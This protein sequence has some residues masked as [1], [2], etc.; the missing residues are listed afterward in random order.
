ML[1]YNV[2]LYLSKY[3]CIGLQYTNLFYFYKGFLPL[4]II[5]PSI[6]GNIFYYKCQSTNS[7]L[8]VIFIKMSFYRLIVYCKFIY[9]SFIHALSSTTV[10]NHIFDI[11]INSR[12]ANNDRNYTSLHN[13]ILYLSKYCFYVSI[14]RNDHS[15]HRDFLF[16][17]MTATDKMC[18]Y[19]I[20]R[21]A[22][23]SLTLHAFSTN[24]Y[25]NLI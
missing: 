23:K 22:Y 21:H 6:S 9:L 7:L 2:V 25:L 20:R 18:S 4:F 16:T 1:L 15:Y 8:Y 3:R 24:V 5:K 13:M 17:S 19:T 11:Y 10:Y 12:K 14:T